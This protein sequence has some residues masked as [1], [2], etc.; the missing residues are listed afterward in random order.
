MI[1]KLCLFYC[2]W[3]LSQY[4]NGYQLNYFVMLCCNTPA[5][6]MIND[7]GMD[8]S[9]SVNET[10]DI[11][12]SCTARGVPAPTITWSR[13]VVNL[14]GTENR[15]T[16]SSP[17]E[18]TD[19]STGFI[20]VTSTLTVTNSMRSD[21]NNY[22]CVAFNTVQGSTQQDQGTFTLTVNCKS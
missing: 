1:V 22:T 12:L 15:I 8:S 18:S 7:P 9:V 13:D 16:I 10:A 6:A 20:D 19:N 21:A 2:I 5:P 3:S 14:S 11:S 4:H 17:M